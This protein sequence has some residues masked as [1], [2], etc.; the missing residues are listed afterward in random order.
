MN[1]KN[2]MCIIFRHLKKFYDISRPI[3]L[4][5]VLGDASGMI[6]M[7]Y[8]IVLVSF[9]GRMRSQKNYNFKAKNKCCD[10]IIYVLTIYYFTSAFKKTDQFLIRKRLDSCS[11]WE[12]LD[13]SR[14]CIAIYFNLYP[15]K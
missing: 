6:C 2:L 13:Y 15:I 5:Q 3:G 4:I 11:L 1:E 10:F 14:T 9:G 8:L 12:S 7:P